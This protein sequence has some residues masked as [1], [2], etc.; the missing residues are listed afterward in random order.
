MRVAATSLADSRLAARP[1]E[2]V[3]CGLCRPV[4]ERGPVRPQ[5]KRFI[6]SSAH[7]SISN[8]DRGVIDAKHPLPLS[9]DHPGCGRKLQKLERVT[10]RIAELDGCYASR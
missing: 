5:A 9:R 7:A 6:E 2:S 1:I 8:A 10:L 4:I 3:E